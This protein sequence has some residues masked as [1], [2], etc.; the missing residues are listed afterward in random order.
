MIIDK[1]AINDNHR[2][3]DESGDVA[4][5]RVRQQVSGPHEA[6]RAIAEFQDLCRGVVMSETAGSGHGPREPARS[7]VD[8]DDEFARTRP[9]ANVTTLTPSPRRVS[10]RNPGARRL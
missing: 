1:Q 5:G 7:V 8:I 9:F 2:L 4:G 6:A 3:V 10:T